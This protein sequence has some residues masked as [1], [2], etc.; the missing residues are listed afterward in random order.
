MA[1]DPQDS[2]IRLEPD[3]VFSLFAEVALPTQNNE[4][5]WVLRTFPQN[6]DK[7]QILKMVAQSAVPVSA[8]H[9]ASI[10]QGMVTH[11]SFVI[12]AVD[13]KWSFGFVRHTPQAPTC[14][15]LVSDLPWHDTFYRLLNH[16]A[17]LTAKR[18]DFLA[19]DFL[20]NLY[21]AAVPQPGFQ[22]LI[23]YNH[24]RSA[25]SCITCDHTATP[26][27]PEDRNLTEYYNACDHNI[28]I[29]I[30]TAM[31]HERRIVIVSR[32]LNRLS[33]CV[34]AA[35]LLIYPM[36]WQHLF[37]PVLPLGLVDTLN[38]P[39]PYLIGVP[40]STW[41]RVRQSE[42]GDVVIYHADQNVFTNP[43]H[44]R[45]PQD[46]EQSLKHKLKIPDAQLG[47]NFAQAF[48]HILVVLIG[49]YRSGF[50]INPQTGSV[51]FDRERF[52]LSQP[53]SLRPFLEGMLQ[54]QIFAEFV[55]NRMRRVN[56]P[57]MDRFELDAAIFKKNPHKFKYK[58]WL[59]QK[60]ASAV[61]SAYKQ[62]KQT[63]NLV[64]DKGKKAYKEIQ[65]KINSAGTH[66]KF[67]R[68]H[69]GVPP[70]LQ[71]MHTSPSIR[72]GPPE[73]PPP[74]E[75]PIPPRR[76]TSPPPAVP[77]VNDLICLEDSPQKSYAPEGF[78]DRFV[79]PTQ[80]GNGASQLL[81]SSAL[82]FHHS[83]SD[84]VLNTRRY[85]M[86][87]DYGGEPQEYLT[88][89]TNGLRISSE[90]SQVNPA[91]VRSATRAGLPI[92]QPPP[93]KADLKRPSHHPPRPP[94]GSALHLLNDETRLGQPPPVWAPS[95]P[96]TN[97][98]AN[99]I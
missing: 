34:Q 45:L 66:E 40:S 43:F 20:D 78:E 4:Q 44:D 26:S 32:R 11:F 54:L 63:G 70:T 82:L 55:E 80:N 38:A 51:D 65:T 77:V 42:M 1:G 21:R 88:K 49:D 10:C 93:R 67:P 76:P 64:K 23:N 7:H 29:Q 14:L 6:F 5:P 25:W 15:V 41:E 96:P 74:P 22:L 47:D 71:R 3:R 18:E 81:S 2:R 85:S 48:M 62:V 52:L 33:S 72:L 91:R 84:N 56:E 89:I 30:F 58:E 19:E 28:M 36:Q 12:T 9:A 31:L 53:S 27:I 86:D 68:R 99:P 69:S 87:F 79:L 83:A 59:Q 61:R 97:P 50:W 13:S 16:I 95:R 57:N 17:D 37:I 75:R 39:M 24:G 35:N 98:F 92:L 60:P 46:L 8:E 73:R 90:P 94:R